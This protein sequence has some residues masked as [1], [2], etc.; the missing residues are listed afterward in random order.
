[1]TEL[2]ETVDVE[3]DDLADEFSDETLD[4]G[5]AIFCGPT[6]KTFRFACVIATV[7]CDKAHRV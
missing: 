2:D 4:C 5:T 1:M 6:G 3:T 7:V